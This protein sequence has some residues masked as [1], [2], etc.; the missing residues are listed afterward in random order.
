MLEELKILYLTEN[1]V[2][3]IDKWIAENS[4]TLATGHFELYYEFGPLDETVTMSFHRGDKKQC[5]EV[6][7]SCKG[8]R[9]PKNIGRIKIDG[10]PISLTLAEKT[11]EK[12]I[13][14]SSALIEAEVEATCEPSGCGLCLKISS[15]TRAVFA[16]E[17]LICSQ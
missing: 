14:V 6:F 16:C 2:E 13:Q 4:F 8:E 1:E 11:L 10:Q 9:L 17:K 5:L 3:A 15:D 12:F 7:D